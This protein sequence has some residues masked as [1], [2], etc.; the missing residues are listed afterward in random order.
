MNTQVFH[1][2]AVPPGQ[3][4]VLPAGSTSATSYLVFEVDT[5]PYA[6]PI[7]R[8]ERLM[9]FDDVVLLPRTADAPDW[10]LGRLETADH[11]A[12]LPVASARNLWGLQALSRG[13]H[14]KW[15]A[16]LVVKGNGG[17]HALLVDEC[18]C[19]LSQLPTGGRSFQLPTALRG[20]RGGAFQQATA[21]GS[22]LLIVLDLEA[23]L[24]PLAMA[25]P[26]PDSVLMATT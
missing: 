23:L 20:D 19:V 1:R 18:R 2:T 21:W 24:R 7:D 26:V 5:Q 22:L 11:P 6:L 4:P 10:E 15:Q 25:Q 17:Q 3:E 8:I 13:A 14:Q 9:R 16:I 12:G